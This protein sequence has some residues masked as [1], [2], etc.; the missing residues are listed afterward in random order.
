MSL[1][2]ISIQRPVFTWVLM[3]GLILFGVLGYT[4][5]GVDQFP[6]MDFPMVVVTARLDGASPEGI[7]EDVTDVLEEQLN[8]IGG[9]RT[10]RSTSSRAHR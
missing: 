9:V 4:R 5:L 3:F 7:E 2:D 10:L 6:E 8:A 1:S